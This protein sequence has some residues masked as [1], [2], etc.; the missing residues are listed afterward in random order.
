[1][2]WISSSWASSSSCYPHHPG[3]VLVQAHSAH[4]PGVAHPGAL[5]AVPVGG[6][7]HALL[8]RPPFPFPDRLESFPKFYHKVLCTLSNVKPRVKDYYA[9]LGVDPE[10]D[11]EA[12]KRVFRKLSVEHH[13]DKVGDDKEKLKHF[14]EIREAS[15]MLTKRRTDCD[16]SIENQEHDEMAPRCEM[17]MRDD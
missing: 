14:N 1:M 11:Q 15:D 13:P 6:H 5:H 9:I 7:L 16:K 4:V 2:G 10:D 12:V 3:Q 8:P 17:L